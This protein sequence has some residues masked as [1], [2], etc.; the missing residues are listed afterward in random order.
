MKKIFSITL[1][2]LCANSFAEVYSIPEDYK[3]L[4]KVRSKKDASYS[5]IKRFS[6]FATIKTKLTK[7]QAKNCIKEII[8]EEYSDDN[9]TNAI[10]VFLYE[11]RNQIGK[12][13]FT[14]AKGTFAPQGKWAKAGKF[15]KPS[16]NKLVMEYDTQ[17]FP[18]KTKSKKRKKKSKKKSGKLSTSTR[19]KIFKEIVALQDKSQRE[20]DSAHPS[21]NDFMANID[22]Q[23]A[24]ESKYRKRIMKKYKLKSNDLYKIS[25]EGVKKRWP[26]D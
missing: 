1:L 2:L 24:R 26:M 7:K 10:M 16:K 13:P 14:V 25:G 23:R 18:G 19:M 17:Y 11:Y 9:K 15:T 5:S 6:I 21:P 8:N 4:C 22:Y 12:Y 3:D 20:A